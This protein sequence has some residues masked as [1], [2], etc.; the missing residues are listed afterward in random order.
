M[1]Y[2]SHHIGDFI[3][4]TANLNDHQLATYLRMLWA[5]YTD[6]KPISGELED[7][8]FAMRSDE[9]T[10]RLLLRHYFTE[11][12]EGW[13]HSRCDREIS[14]Y[15]GKSE[16][17]KQSA[18]ARWSNTNADANASEGINSDGFPSSKLPRKNAS[19]MRTH[20]E[21]N[22]NASISDANQE[23][24]TNNHKK[25]TTT[26]K[27]SQPIK[28]ADVSDSVW[29][30]F[31]QMRK[32]KRAIVTDTALNAI[33]RQA[34]KAGIT[35]QNALEECCQRGWTGFK[36]EWMDN[37]TANRTAGDVVHESPWEAAGRKRMQELSPG[38]ARRA[39]EPI[40]FENFSEGVRN[41]SVIESH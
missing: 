17:A 22:T 19:A 23:P 12:P 10:V 9:K 26:R 11:T 14:A 27:S 15:H 2:Y 16:K 7:I 38:A 39:P 20:T 33:A 35:L 36:A 34:T 41:V 4:D 28:P 30:D 24:I 21:R 13:T 1:H 6:E 3:K 32:T 31:L 37:K 5:Y 8:A 29:D 40:T 25:E 18:K